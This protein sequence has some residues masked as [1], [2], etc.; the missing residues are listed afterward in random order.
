MLKNWHSSLEVL[1]FFFRLGEDDLREK[2]RR[3]RPRHSAVEHTQTLGKIILRIS[4][5]LFYMVFFFGLFS[6]CSMQ[7]GKQG[8]HLY[9]F[10]WI[11]T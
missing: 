7:T 4:V 5:F 10:S 3:R 6:C 8:L 11:K 1:S 9:T 2:K